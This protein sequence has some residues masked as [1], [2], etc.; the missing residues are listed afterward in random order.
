MVA[1]EEVQ[2]IL[3]YK[4]SEHLCGAPHVGNILPVSR[5]KNQK[6][7][8]IPGPTGSKFLDGAFRFWLAKGIDNG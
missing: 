4:K 6:Y 8:K 3:S 1:L 2:Q 7:T 5:S